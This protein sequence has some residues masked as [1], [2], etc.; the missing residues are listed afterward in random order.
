MLAQGNAL[1][2]YRNESQALKGRPIGQRMPQSLAKIYLHLVFS[3]K[4]R[5][6]VINEKIRDP[7][8]RYMATV[9][10]TSWL[11]PKPDQFRR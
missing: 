11:P 3:T 9:L 10:K 2:V 4:N 6:P 1:G 8:H 5:T 7:L